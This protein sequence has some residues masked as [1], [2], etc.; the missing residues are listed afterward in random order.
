MWCAKRGR[1]VV[2]TFVLVCAALLAVCACEKKSPPP[3]QKPVSVGVVTASLKDAP[4][5]VRGVG[6]VLAMRTVAV[7]P[8]VTGRLAELFFQEGQ[9]VT[10]GQPLAAIDPQPFQARVDE[11]SGALK[12][13]W[14]KADQAGRDFLRYKDL[15]RKEVVSEEDYE[16]KRM[17][18]QAGWQQVKADQAT[19][20]AARIDLGYCRITSPVS[21]VAGYQNIKPG[22]TV[23]AYTSTIV[24]INQIQ[25]VLV[26]FSVNEGEL[27]QVREHFAKRPVP[28]TARLPKEEADLKERGQLTAIDNVID[29]Q[30]GMILLQAQF[31]NANSRLW[32]GQFVTVTCTLDV[33]K[34]RVVVPSDAV[35][36]R[37]D[38]SFL[39]VVQ[40]AKA[41]LR[42]VRL[43][44][45]VGQK[46]VVILE[47][48]A[49]GE[50]VIAE[51]VIRVAP[52]GPVETRP[53]SEEAGS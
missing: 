4:V 41:Q 19:L 25:P 11:A 50:T 2:K 32:P 6:H 15:V 16:Q 29:T 43:G 37:Q 18:F 35:M 10:Q 45:K 1:G 42:K 30:T 24:T 12:R 21:G 28:A 39:F 52:G 8:Q 53:M 38:G 36:S 9:M 3:A 26:R 51:G 17:D 13:D 5:T 14:A 48:L 46:E 33:E 47:G 7:Q 20:D 40:D 23:S 22:N 31:D 49:V 44:R 27:A 34:N